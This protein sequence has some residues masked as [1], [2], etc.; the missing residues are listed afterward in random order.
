[1]TQVVLTDKQAAAGNSSPRFSIV[2]LVGVLLLIAISLAIGLPRYRAGMD[3]GDEGFLAYG[4]MRV[5]EGQ[6]P[7]RDFVSLQ[8]PLSFYVAALTFQILGT[9]LASL[10]ILGLSIHILIP[11]FIYGVGRTLR[12]H[13]LSAVAAALPATILGI[14]YF[15]FVPFAVWQGITITLA[16]ILVYMNALCSGR[17]WLALS[18]GIL[19][20]ISIFLRH[21]QGLYLAISI[22]ILTVA[23]KFSPRSTTASAQLNKV[24][25]SWCTAAL[26]VALGF[27][28][29]WWLEGALPEMFK[30]LV[31]FPITTYVKTSS[32]PFPRFSSQVSIEEN[33]L[34]VLFYLPPL[35]IALA[36]I[37]LVR[38]ILRRHFFFN[39]VV[40]TFLTAWSALFYCQVLTRSDLMHLL[41]TLPP[42]FLLVAFGWSIFLEQFGKRK[43]LKVSLSILAVGLASCHLWAVSP[44]ALPERPKELET[45][46]LSRGGVRIENARWM[47]EFIRGVQDYV[48]PDRSILVL[49]Y[50]PMFYFL[51]KRHNPTRWNYLW[52][53]DQT[54]ADHER[55]IQEAKS[56]PPAVVFI[57][58][59]TELSSFAPAILDYVHREY[60]L[61]VI[62]EPLSVYFPQ[63]TRP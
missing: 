30:Q 51:C 56:D 29:Y 42:F 9:S 53:G 63:E 28:I 60:R 47:A 48:P 49:P 46:E 20:T 34:T 55:L 23:L 54:P 31:V 26:V 11:L 10:R 40:L 12:L 59:E 22:L 50:Q 7:Q 3:W 5:M 14:P 17:V 62:F 4:T 41:T 52:P 61:A 8:P 13:P 38:Q 44:R 15:N 21:D 57:N 58:Y 35:F 18:A 33:A 32:E 43:V 25:F 24:F 36:T 27:V 2:D 45:L 16:A 1:M 37:W 6:L 39:E 19:T